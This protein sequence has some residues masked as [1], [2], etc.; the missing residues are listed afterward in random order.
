MKNNYAKRIILFMAI[1][2]TIIGFWGCPGSP[3]NIQQSSVTDTSGTGHKPPGILSKA[4][5]DTTTS[6]KKPPK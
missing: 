4:V 2:I 5:S 6:G 1:S 3:S